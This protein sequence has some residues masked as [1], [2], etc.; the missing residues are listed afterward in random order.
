MQ[1]SVHIIM[2]ATEVAVMGNV[3]DGLK[4]TVLS[5]VYKTCTWFNRYCMFV[6]PNFSPLNEL[7]HTEYIV[8]QACLLDKA[9]N[10]P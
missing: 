5:V 1:I 3:S 7:K 6:L 9:L 2:D 4:K 10:F 8:P